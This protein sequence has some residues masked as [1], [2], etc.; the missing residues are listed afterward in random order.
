MGL[1]AVPRDCLD[2]GA[3]G[4]RRALQCVGEV[5]PR[6][7]QA[8][9]PCVVITVND[10][11]KRSNK[12]VSVVLF[13]RLLGNTLCEVLLV[14]HDRA[15]Q[16]NITSDGVTDIT[17]DKRSNGFI[18]VCVAICRKHNDIEVGGALVNERQVLPKM[19]HVD[20]LANECD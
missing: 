9:A 18:N 12:R 14:R 20:G 15:P 3:V 17:K 4:D 1:D 8:L 2:W 16:C 6:L 13:R 19:P 11:S 5:L 7:T 10:H